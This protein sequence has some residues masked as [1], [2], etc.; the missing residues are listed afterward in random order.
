MNRRQYI[1]A[2]TAIPIAALT[3]GCT[4][5]DGGGGLTETVV[6]SV[7][8][9]EG[10]GAAPPTTETDAPA[11]EI[12]ATEFERVGP[13]EFVVD[14]AVRNVGEEPVHDLLLEVRLYEASGGEEGFFDEAVQERDFV[15]LS[16]GEDWAFRLHFNDVEIEDVAHYSVTVTGSFDTPE[17]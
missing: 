1:R 10:G 13:N 12:E 17:S 4:G 7:G 3:A 5:G 16:P 2:A 6:V 14:G 9:G 8:D 15:L 11:L